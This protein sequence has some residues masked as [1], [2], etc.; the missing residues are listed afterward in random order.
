MG[1]W[2]ILRSAWYIG[3]CNDLFKGDDLYRGDYAHDI[4]VAGKHG[5]EEASDHDE[6]PYRPS[7]ERLLLFVVFRLGWWFFFT[8]TIH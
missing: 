5:E 2:Y 1:E 8:V 4:D 6:G 7:Y 3:D